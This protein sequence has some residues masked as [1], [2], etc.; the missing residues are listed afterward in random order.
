MLKAGDTVNKGITRRLLVVVLASLPVLSACSSSGNTPPTSGPPSPSGSPSNSAPAISPSN[1]APAIT[2]GTS[3][4]TIKIGLDIPYSGSDQFEGQHYYQASKLI[5][6]E[7]NATGGFMGNKV[8]FFLG[9]NQCDPST[10]VSAV[11]KLILNDKV[12][13]IVGSGCSSVALAVMPLL[14][15]YKIPEIDATATNPTISQQSGVGGNIWKF[16]LNLDDGLMDTV[17]AQKIVAPES[18]KVAIISV[19]TDYG[20]AASGLLQQSLASSGSSVIDV[21]YHAQGAPDFRSQ[22]TK[23]KGENPDGIVMVEDYPDGATILLQAHEL[24]ITGVKWYGRGSVVVNDMITVMSKADPSGYCPLINGI[25]EVNFWA[26]NSGS[27]A[28]A[29]EYQKMFSTPIHRDVVLSYYA[30]RLVLDAIKAEGGKHDADSIRLGLKATSENLP[31]LGQITFDDH[32]QAHYPMSIVTFQDCKVLTLGTV[33][34][35]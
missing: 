4:G 18:K 23:V 15:Q 34:T 24:G 12:D 29:A 35:F 1:S 9:D 5:E 22:L 21:I 19:N 2:Q 14:E 8:E 6:A 25:K 28:L 27:D 17:L 32:N 16:R 11:R 30:I 3:G 31:G 7:L 10:G 13:A 20:R 33:P 26:P